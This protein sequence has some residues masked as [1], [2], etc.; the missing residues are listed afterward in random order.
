VLEAHLQKLQAALAGRGRA[1]L[2]GG[3][4]ELA[5]LVAE[6]RREDYARFGELG[7]RHRSEDPSQKL[8]RMLGTAEAGSA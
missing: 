5:E 8:R 1:T 7:R 4:L 3:M 6:R 2:A